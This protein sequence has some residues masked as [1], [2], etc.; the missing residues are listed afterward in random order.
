MHDIYKHHIRKV[1]IAV[2]GF[3]QCLPFSF[4]LTFDLCK[5]EKQQPL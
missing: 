4:C 2:L 1:D 3:S 5:P